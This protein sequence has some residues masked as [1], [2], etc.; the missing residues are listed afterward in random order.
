MR[1]LKNLIVIQINHIS[2]ISHI[3]FRNVP[4]IRLQAHHK[5][6]RRIQPIEKELSHVRNENVFVL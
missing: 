5:W 1:H 3:L 2:T 6:G 4:I